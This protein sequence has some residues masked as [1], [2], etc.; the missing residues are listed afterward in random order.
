MERN[1]KAFEKLQTVEQKCLFSSPVFAGIMPDSLPDNLS[2][3]ARCPEHLLHATISNIPPSPSPEI[4]F[5]E[6]Y[7]L[8]WK[9][10]RALIARSGPARN[11]R[12]IGPGTPQNYPRLF[13]RHPRVT[14]AKDCTAFWLEWIALEQTCWNRIWSWAHHVNVVK[15]KHPAIFSQ[16]ALC[17]NHQMVLMEYQNKQR[18]IS[19]YLPIWRK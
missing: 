4:H 2:L 9:S 13:H 5:N 7:K 11:G 6:L 8:C 12:M 16:T 3:K 14:Q 10:A 17:I 19:D 15:S 18:L 1:G